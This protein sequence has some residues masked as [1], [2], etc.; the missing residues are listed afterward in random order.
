MFSPPLFK[1]H[2]GETV[3][4]IGIKKTLAKSLAIFLPKRSGMSSQD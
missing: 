1:K 3:N 2:G 4:K